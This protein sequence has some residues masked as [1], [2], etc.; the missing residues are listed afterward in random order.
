MTMHYEHQ[1]I[2]TFE[3]IAESEQERK[4]KLKAF[5]RK[6]FNQYG[7]TDDV[8]LTGIRLKDND[9]RGGQN[10]RVSISD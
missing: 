6:L 5:K 10:L 7:W 8:W 9:G 4:E 1:W 2:M 3:I